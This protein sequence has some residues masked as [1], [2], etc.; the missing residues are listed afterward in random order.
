[1][2]AVLAA[3]ATVAA[4]SSSG[5][6]SSSSSGSSSVSAAATTQSSAASTSSGGANIAAAQAIVAANIKTDVPL[7]FPTTPVKMGNKRVAIINVGENSNYGALV[8]KYFDAA[9]QATGWQ[10][11]Q[12][13]A[14]LD[15]VKMAG[16]I[17]EAVQQK[18][19]AIIV[20]SGNLQY[21][22]SS[23]QA[24]ISAKIPLIC[25]DCAPTAASIADKVI[26]TGEDWSQTGQAI[27]AALIARSGDKTDIVRWDE[28]AYPSISITTAGLAA[29]YKKLCPTCKYAQQE[30]V[31]TDL[32]QPGPPVWT[33]FLSSHPAGSGI[34]DVVAD[35]DF[36]AQAMQATE[37]QAGRSDIAISSTASLGV[38][39]NDIKTGATKGIA[40]VNPT[41][42]ECWAALDLAARAM[43]GMKLYNANNLYS[44]LVVQSNASKFLPDGNYTPD[45]VSVPAKFEAL[46][47]K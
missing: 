42:F 11:T 4:C 8:K 22:A 38:E 31:A 40:T 47:Q 41:E 26:T 23:V 13:D 27:A 10:Y 6:S 33:A 15:P 5:S 9:A 16:Y 30:Y 14:Q 34:T 3:A 18:Y 19:D 24:V 25:V 7:P 2:L 29:E 28:T 12:F 36:L 45:G 1:M 35:D 17:Q 37:N 46:W 20:D 44:P 21:L 32:A 39:I 43:D